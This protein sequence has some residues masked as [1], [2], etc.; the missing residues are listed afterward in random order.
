MD[1]LVPPD[2]SSRKAAFGIP[3]GTMQEIR[4]EFNLLRDSRRGFCGSLLHGY[5]Q[6]TDSF[7]PLVSHSQTNELRKNFSLEFRSIM[8]LNL[9]KPH[10]INSCIFHLGI[11]IYK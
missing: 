5:D 2:F 1:I 9:T 8:L 10:L 3:M 6:I 11:K 7:Q 4:E